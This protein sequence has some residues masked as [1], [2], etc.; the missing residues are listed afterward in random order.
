M[1]MA[2][3]AVSDK[4]AGPYEYLGHVQYADGTIMMKYVCFDPAVIN[5]NGVIRI[6]YGTQYDYEER[7]DFDTD[8]NYLNIEMGMFGKQHF[9]PSVTRNCIKTHKPCWGLWVFV[10]R[11]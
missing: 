1:G 9:V 5:D 7:E 10:L 6:Y 11:V 8:P 3:I 4:P 2:V